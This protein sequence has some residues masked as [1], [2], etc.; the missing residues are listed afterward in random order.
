LNRELAKAIRKA[1]RERLEATLILQIRAAGLPLPVQQHRFHPA[2]RWAF[3]FAWVDHQLACEVQGGTFSGGAHVRGAGY[4]RDCE[5]AQAALLLGWRIIP[6]TSE[7]VTT[8]RALAVLEA[9][10]TRFAAPDESGA[11]E[12]RC[13]ALEE[14]G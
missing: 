8:G 5:K 7:D 9:A 11:V 14:S 2:R 4:Q 3:D 12:T 1:A 13:S 6:V 10:L